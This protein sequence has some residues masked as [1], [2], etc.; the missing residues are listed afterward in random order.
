M[1]NEKG[2]DG[3]MMGDSRIGP[4]AFLGTQTDRWVDLGIKGLGIG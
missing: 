1:L 4:F 3:W 2:K